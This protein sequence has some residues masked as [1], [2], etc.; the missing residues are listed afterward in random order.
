[1]SR[2]WEKKQRNSAKEVGGKK[3]KLAGEKP[4]F[5]QLLNCEIKAEK[6]KK[7][8]HIFN[9]SLQISGKCFVKFSLGILR[10]A[11]LTVERHPAGVP[12]N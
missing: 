3:L 8:Q 2:K 7:K 1:M 5:L 11:K 4:I 12:E 10:S 6:D 9:L